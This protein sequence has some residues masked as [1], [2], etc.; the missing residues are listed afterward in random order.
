MSAK[1]LLIKEI[2]EMSETELQ[3]ILII[4]QELKNKFN[5]DNKKSK[6]SSHLGSGKSILRHAGKWVGDDWQE[7]LNLVYSSRGNAEF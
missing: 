7:C 2:E 5:S 4:I 1:E 6:L 3:Q